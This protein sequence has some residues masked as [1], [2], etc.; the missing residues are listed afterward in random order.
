[1]PNLIDGSVIN[2][3]AVLRSNELKR[4][5][6]ELVS[7]PFNVV[8]EMKYRGA[9]IEPSARVPKG[10]VIDL[11]VMDG[12]IIGGFAV[13]DLVGQ[14]LEDAKVY[15]LGVSLNMEVNLAGDTTGITPVVLK[16]K[17]EGGEKIKV[18]DVVHLWVG[19][20]GTEVPEEDIN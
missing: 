6:I 3:E 17:P 4:G 10:A 9:K 13:D 11:V 2:A 12:G 8:K 16:Q 20:E 5:R 19:K 14:E 7:G 1:V 15:L 18:G